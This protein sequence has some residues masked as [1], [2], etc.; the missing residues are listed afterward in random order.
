MKSLS[1]LLLMLAACSDP[2]PSAPTAEEVEQLD[3]AEELLN[4]EAANEKGPE[5][6]A[7]GPS[8]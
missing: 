4:A 5:A 6:N 7:S 1:I 2:G 8:Q 3:E